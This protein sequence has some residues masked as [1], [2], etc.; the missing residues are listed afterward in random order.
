[1]E[2]ENEFDQIAS[3]LAK[4]YDLSL[5]ASKKII[6]ETVS[7]VYGTEYPS[8]LKDDGAYLTYLDDKGE[9]TFSKITFS[10][11]KKKELLVKL[12][13]NAMKCYLQEVKKLVTFSINNKKNYLY[14]SYTYSNDTNDY[15]SLFFDKK[16]TK[17]VNHV[18]GVTKHN[19]KKKKRIYIN[20]YSSKI[21]KNNIYFYEDKRY[22][23]LVNLRELTKELS[24]EIYDKVKIKIWIEVRGFDFFNRKIYLYIPTK[25]LRV[26]IEFIE[27]KYLEVFDLYVVLIYET[28]GAKDDI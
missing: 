23:N 11:K 24:K 25:T 2:N 28:K 16:L 27:K 21:V 18:L 10:I 1:M 12:D 6:I 26:I 3:D 15:Y 9:F 4:Q 14:S 19:S 17:K 7:E 13:K 5:K 20:L 8:V 22:V